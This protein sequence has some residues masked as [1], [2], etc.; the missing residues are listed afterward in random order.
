M[1][2]KW[3]FVIGHSFIIWHFLLFRFSLCLWMYDLSSSNLKLWWFHVLLIKIFII[4]LSCLLWYFIGAILL[5]VGLFYLH[6]EF[7]T[8]LLCVG[9]FTCTHS[10]F[11]YPKGLKK[12]S[13]RYSM[14]SGLKTKSCQLSLP[15]TRTYSPSR[16]RC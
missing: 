8:C 13:A 4:G 12:H 2:K 11:T 16:S 9:F 1:S 10:C 14:R 6:T 7:S 3:L 5:C 15:P